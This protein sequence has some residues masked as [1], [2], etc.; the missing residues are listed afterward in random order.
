MSPVCGKATFCLSH[1]KPFVSTEQAHQAV[2]PRMAHLTVLLGE[3][4]ALPGKRQAF[5]SKSPYKVGQG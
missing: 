2:R 3:V 5:M 4:C 1:L